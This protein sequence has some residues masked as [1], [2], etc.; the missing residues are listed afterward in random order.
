MYD[1]RNRLSAQVAE[2]VRENLGNV[3]FT[4]MIPRNVR[5]SEAP[6]Y[7][8]AVLLYD[9]QCAGSQAYRALA[10]ELLARDGHSLAA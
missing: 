5:L 1:Q 9:P 2:D 4:T 8:Q 7:G 10:S 6:S 3:V